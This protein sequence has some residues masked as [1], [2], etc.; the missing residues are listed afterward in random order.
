MTVRR[1][2]DLMTRA[3]QTLKETGAGPPLLLMEGASESALVGF[4]DV[5]KTAEQRASLFFGVGMRL[6][7]LRPHRAIGVLDAYFK[8]DLDGRLP[9]G[10]LADDPAAQDCIMV[11]S[12]DRK[13][14]SRMLLCP[15]ERRPALEGLRIR[16]KPMRWLSEEGG[17]P[18]ILEAFFAGV[19]E[20]EG[21]PS[22]AF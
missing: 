4:E 21:H 9:V 3:R 7:H 16:F 19:R 11:V 22:Q 12:L 5:G 8:A 13:G 1:M 14:R 20:A 17:R 6:A 15:Y 2:R 18:Y 10:S